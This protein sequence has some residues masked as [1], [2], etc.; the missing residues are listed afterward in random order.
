MRTLRA[1]EKKYAYGYEYR[2]RLGNR[3]QWRNAAS[4]A[5]ASLATNAKRKSAP[6]IPA[7]GLRD[8]SWTHI[9]DFVLDTCSPI[10]SSRKP[11]IKAKHP[12]ADAI[13]IPK[14]RPRSKMRRIELFIIVRLYSSQSGK[15]VHY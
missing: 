1:P 14:V 13:R 3:D 5:R 8:M 15:D 10:E 6:L 12:A 7:N 4:V 11:G 9:D 2:A